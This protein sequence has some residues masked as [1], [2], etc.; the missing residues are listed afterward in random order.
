MAHC[1]RMIHCS[2][3]YFYSDCSLEEGV[4]IDTIFSRI[5]GVTS[6][7]EAC[8]TLQEE[9]Q[10]SAK[11]CASKFQTLQ[12]EFELIKMKEYHTIEEYYSKIKEIVSQMKTYRENILYKKIVEKIL[13]SIPHK[14]VAIVTTIEQ[15]K[16][17]STLSVIELMNSLEAYE[18]K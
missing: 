9:F 2:N 15:I 16:D 18:E 8:N 14:Y 17:L 6:A 3:R 1:R 10:G 7:K 4:V 11:V 12:C 13:I 5:M